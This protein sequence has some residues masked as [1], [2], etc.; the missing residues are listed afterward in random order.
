MKDKF[1][2]MCYDIAQRIGEQHPETLRCEG[3]CYGHP[4]QLDGD[5]AGWVWHRNAGFT[6]E[7]AIVYGGRV[8]CVE[9]PLVGHPGFDL[10]G[11]DAQPEANC[12][13]KNWE[14]A[15]GRYCLRCGTC[16]ENYGD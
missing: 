9:I 14:P 12:D 6:F 16:M 15:S 5:C 11:Q 13:H 8:R 7:I 3:E 2:Q 4:V 1:A 10:L